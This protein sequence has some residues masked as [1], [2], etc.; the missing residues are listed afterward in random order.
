MDNLLSSD[1]HF[2][3]YYSYFL[4]YMPVF[5][6][7]DDNGMCFEKVIKRH[8]MFLNIIKISLRNLYHSKFFS[9]INILG[10]TL[11]LTCSIIILI[12][13]QQELS[14]D[15]FHEKK[16]NIFILQTRMDLGSG[17]YT[18]DRCGAAVG[19]ALTEAFPTITSYLR[20]TL[21]QEMLFTL[22]PEDSV[23]A[24]PSERKNYLESGIIAVDSNFLSFFSFPVL[25]GDA[26]SA[27]KD[28]FSLVMT[29]TSAEKYFGKNNPLNK[30]IR[31]NAEHELKITAIL[32]DPPVTSSI[33]FDFLVSFLSLILTLPVV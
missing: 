28:P 10:L 4:H 21:P 18:T 22:Y 33:Q 20:H 11:G 8:T 2:I 32:E 12:L 3:H 17:S 23:S 1:G 31:V 25:Q 19:P 15:R 24:G 27:L 26:A 16:D 5:Q 29:E 30:I 7:N 13:I 6:Y 9:L 14:Y